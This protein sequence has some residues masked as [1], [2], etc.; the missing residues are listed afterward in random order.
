M[1]NA[2][3]FAFDFVCAFTMAF[4][5]SALVVSFVNCV[6]IFVFFDESCA[7][8]LSAL[9]ILDFIFFICLGVC[10]SSVAVLP[11]LIFSIIA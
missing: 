9:A 2:N 1:S 3:V 5:I 11:D 7:I 4:C 8:S 10:A 6:F